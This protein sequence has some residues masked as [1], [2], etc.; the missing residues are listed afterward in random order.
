M[1]DLISQRRKILL[2]ITGATQLPNTWI[3]PVIDS[4]VLPAH[5][6]TSSTT[7][8]VS[9][10][11]T[12]T[13][14]LPPMPVSLIYPGRSF[15][16]CRDPSGG[17]S[18]QFSINDADVTAPFVDMSGSDV[19]IFP[20]PSF[21]PGAPSFSLTIIV[22]INGDITDAQLTNT[23]NNQ[24]SAC[25]PSSNPQGGG[26]ITGMVTGT[27]NGTVYTVSGNLSV[28]GQNIIL[29]DLIFTP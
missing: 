23:H 9:P 7:T 14:P 21:I 25:S 11:T 12:S 29:S 13:P 27:V 22:N 18:I 6:Q 24:P 28:S 2:G 15:D 5:A 20:F 3:K 17:P 1:K 26:S 4:V 16:V 8:T 19:I 10:S